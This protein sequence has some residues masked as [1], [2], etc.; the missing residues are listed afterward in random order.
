M[1]L[2]TFSCVYQRPL[3]CTGISGQRSKVE[4]KTLLNSSVQMTMEQHELFM[5]YITEYSY[6]ALQGPTSQVKV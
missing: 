5:S 4:N 6:K 2:Y 3:T 1:P